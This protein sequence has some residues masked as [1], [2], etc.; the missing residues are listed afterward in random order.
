MSI[1]NFL[2]KLSL[3]P[4][5]VEFSN[6]M[7]IV[8]RFYDFTETSFTNGDTSNDA[9]QNNGSCKLFAFAKIHQLNQQDTLQCFGNFYREDVL[10]NPDGNDHQ[11]IR[12]FIKHG[13]DGV[14]FSAEALSPK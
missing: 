3:N 9:G 7:D 2:E 12:N 5:T 10:K 4:E 11:N 6:T 8:E 14:S 13:W 1:S